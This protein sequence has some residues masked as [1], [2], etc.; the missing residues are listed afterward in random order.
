MPFIRRTYAH[1]LQVHVSDDNLETIRQYQDKRLLILPNHPGED[2]PVVM[3]SLARQAGCHFYF[4]CMREMFE[5]DSGIRGWLLQRIGGFSVIRGGLDRKSYQM[6]Q[7][8]L[9]SGT[10]P[11]VIFI[12]GE[13]TQENDTLIPFQRGVIHLAMKAQKK[14]KP[15]E[16]PVHLLPVSIRYR[17]LPEAQQHLL[18]GTQKLEAAMDIIPDPK[19]PI[20]NRLRAVGDQVLHNYESLYQINAPIDWELDQRMNAVKEAM[21]VKMEQFLDLTPDPNKVILERVRDIR[22]AMDRRCHVYQDIEDL[23]EY[24]RNQLQH[25]REQFQGF[26]TDLARLLNFLTLHRGSLTANLDDAMEVL[27]RLEHEVF[28]APRTY[29][30][31]TAYLHV[32]QVTPLDQ[33]TDDHD[34]IEAVAQKL[35]GEMTALLKKSS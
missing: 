27:R 19:A 35:E 17:H 31:K 24:E 16:T 20:E 8:I 32:G 5:W 1:G 10:Q 14:L 4:V 6:S 30:P 9:E 22:N 23:S 7:K 34:G 18:E 33:I 3:Y 2:D 13:M 28:G 12:E 21:L 11:L 29:A 25:L 26:Y 15:G